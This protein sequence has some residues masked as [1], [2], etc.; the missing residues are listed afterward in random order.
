MVNYIISNTRYR[1]KGD[2]LIKSSSHPELAQ[3]T[4]SPTRV[5]LTHLGEFKETPDLHASVDHAPG[6]E[7]GFKISYRDRQSP[8][9]SP[10]HPDYDPA[11]DWDDDLHFSASPSAHK[12]F[13]SAGHDFIHQAIE[14]HL[15]FAEH[16]PQDD[17]HDIG[18]GL[19]MWSD[20]ETP[21]MAT[22]VTHAEHGLP[23]KP[24]SLR[25]TAHARAGGEGQYKGGQFV[26]QQVALN[27]QSTPNSNLDD[28]SL[29]ELEADDPK[30]RSV[31]RSPGKTSASSIAMPTQDTAKE[32]SIAQKFWEEESKL[33]HPDTADKKGMRYVDYESPYDLP[34]DLTN[35]GRSPLYQLWVNHNVPELAEIANMPEVKDLKYRYFNTDDFDFDKDPDAFDRFNE[36]LAHHVGNENVENVSV[37]HG[38]A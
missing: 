19:A 33:P 32:L 2:R 6:Y 11:E 4:D 31:L 8:F 13:A 36:A 17:Y 10:G 14:R 18:N 35:T 16:S 7:G 22:I 9:N 34:K 15:N 21:E 27:L 30:Q 37:Y 3:P 20:P 5:K 29:D 23:I 1:W 24:Y 12:I 38:L 25:K 28:A 26:P